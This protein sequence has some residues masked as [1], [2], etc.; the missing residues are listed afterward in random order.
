MGGGVSQIKDN[1]AY[2]LT[3]IVL[4][5]KG[6]FRVKNLAN[7]LG[8]KYL[9]RP[10]K[11]EMKK[12]GNLK[13][14]F[15]NSDS[16]FIIIF[17]ADF[18]PRYDFVI[19][20]L[21]YMEDKK[22]GILQTPQF[23]E[24]NDAIHK[25]SKLQFGAGAIQ[26]DFY[27]IIQRSRDFFGGAI[28]V[29]TNAVYR[30][31]ALEKVGGTYQAEHSED[32]LTGF[33]LLQIG[34]NIKYLPIILAKGLCPDEPIS[35]FNQQYRWCS[36]SMML[37]TNV[38]FWKA[39]VSFFIKM[40]YIS[41]FLYYITSLLS[42][43]FSFQVFIVLLKFIDTISLSNAMFF[44]PYIIFGLIILPLS[45][46]NKPKLGTYIALQ[47]AF[48][49]YSFALF[50]K[51]S[52]KQMGWKVT[53]GKSIVSKD[54]ANL[55]TY[56]SIYFSLYILFV[57]I[58]AY[59]GYVRVENYNHYSILFWIVYNIVFNLILLFTLYNSVLKK[60]EISV[61]SN[62]VN[63]WRIQSFITVC[64]CLVIFSFSGYTLSNRL[65][66]NSQVLGVFN[67]RNKVDTIKITE[68]KVISSTYSIS[69]LSA[70]R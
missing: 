46:I 65:V 50:D 64:V 28:C 4:D 40:C 6:D 53:G 66:N 59:F 61:T 47:T 26:E 7:E 51:I 29:G 36:G 30:R 19:E 42:I 57:S 60:I 33:S 49:S 13:Y 32:V 31:S 56:F 70:K 69:S 37:M 62:F 55:I 35:F 10:N 25:K 39:K 22:L 24:I 21:P 68:V 12:A 16:E 54:Y 17:D 23:F 15:E 18:C 11:G 48:W 67:S 43:I 63:R 20:S 52:G 5:D 8:F 45:R 38:Y 27:R 41:G 2:I 1:P 34:Y 14:G 9:S 3:P 44:Y 58:Y